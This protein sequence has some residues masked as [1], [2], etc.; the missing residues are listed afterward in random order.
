MSTLTTISFTS[1]ISVAER[2]V[3]AID[4]IARSKNGIYHGKVIES[5]S[6]IRNSLEYAEIVIVY[7]MNWKHG[8]SDK[9]VRIPHATNKIAIFRT[10][11]RNISHKTLKTYNYLWKAI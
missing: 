11:V 8:N 4:Y 10:L 1:P 2:I 3:R 5:V 9:E 6:V 7:I